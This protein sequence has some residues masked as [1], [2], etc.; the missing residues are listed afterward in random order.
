MF[1]PHLMA[2]GDLAPNL[3]KYVLKYARYW[4]IAAEKALFYDELANY[5]NKA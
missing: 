5:C 2:D 4:Q 3:A 1:E